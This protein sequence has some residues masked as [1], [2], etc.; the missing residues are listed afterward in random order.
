MF[1]LVAEALVQLG[2]DV[3]GPV[4]GEHVGAHG[5]LGHDLDLRT[6]GTLG[7]HEDGDILAVAEQREAVPSLTF[8]PC[9]M[10]HAEW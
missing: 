9:C 7:T 6:A 5:G 10:E 3:V 4:V 2:E 1:P 8:W